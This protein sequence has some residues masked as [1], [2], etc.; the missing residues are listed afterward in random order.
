MCLQCYSGSRSDQCCELTNRGCAS[1]LSKNHLGL[2]LGL[3][4]LDARLEAV[5]PAG[6][7]PVQ[8]SLP[9]QNQRRGR[10]AGPSATWSESARAVP[11]RTPREA[12]RGGAGIRRPPRP[13]APMR[14]GRSHPSR[15]SAHPAADG[16]AESWTARTSGS[17]ASLPGSSPADPGPGG[18]GGWATC[19]RRD[20]DHCDV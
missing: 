8:E 3:A 15:G 4:R 6:Q 14:P 16:A 19:S 12:R 11:L 20:T 9:L 10:G 7:H 13:C 5:P 1:R 17:R 18:K 2:D